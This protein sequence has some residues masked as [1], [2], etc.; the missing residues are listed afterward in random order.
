MQMGG[1]EMVTHHLAASISVFVS[2]YYREA[3]PYTLA[4]LSTECTTPFINFRWLLEKMVQLFLNFHFLSNLKICLSDCFP[5]MIFFAR[6][7]F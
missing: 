1:W 7:M 3:H 4:L 6:G 2:A 5:S